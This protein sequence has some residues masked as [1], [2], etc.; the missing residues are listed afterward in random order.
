MMAIDSGTADIS[1]FADIK[2]ETWDGGGIYRAIDRDSSNVVGYLRYLVPVNGLP[3]IQVL[4]TYTDPA[5]RGRS[6]A[7]ALG[8]RL[9]LDNPDKKLKL[10]SPQDEGTP[11]RAFWDKQKEIQ[12]DWSDTV[13][14]QDY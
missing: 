8:E 3:V 6:I 12:P 9:H 10:G 14:D 2:L 7:T 11:G 1:E 13:E 4:T 5:W